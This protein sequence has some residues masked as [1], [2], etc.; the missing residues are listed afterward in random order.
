MGF[1]TFLILTV[2]ISFEIKK[3]VPSSMIGNLIHQ[4]F[5]QYHKRFELTEHFLVFKVMSLKMPWV[6]PV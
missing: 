5:V 1:T 4:M 6:N 3:S 2:F